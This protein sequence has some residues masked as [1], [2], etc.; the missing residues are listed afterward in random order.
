M[1]KPWWIFFQIL[2]VSQKVR[3]LILEELYG[4]LICLPPLEFWSKVFLSYYR[5]MGKEASSSS[6]VPSNLRNESYYMATDHE[7]WNGSMLQKHM[8]PDLTG[9]N[10]HQ[11]IGSEVIFYFIYSTKY[12]TLFKIE[13]LLSFEWFKF[14]TFKYI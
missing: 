10:M 4:H 6:I 5:L 9:Q 8:L 1:P 11:R 3:T 7:T 2:C 12:L 14:A 13:S